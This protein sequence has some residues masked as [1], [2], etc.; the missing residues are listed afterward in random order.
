MDLLSL[1][2]A[3]RYSKAQQGTPSLRLAH[4]LMVATTL[5]EAGIVTAGA[6]RDVSKLRYQ[7]VFLMGAGGSGKGFVGERWMKYMPGA[8]PEG[9]SADRGV[10]QEM[11][12]KKLDE[13]E[14][15]L[16]NLNFEKTVEKLKQRGFRIELTEGGEAARVPFRLYTYD[17]NNR[18][19]LVSPA[20]YDN[21]LPNAIL[22]QVR[23]LESVVFKTPV[24]ELPS[25]WRQVNPD[26]YKEE[27]AGYIKREPGYVHEMSSEMSKAYFEAILESGDPV[28]VDQTGANPGKVIAQI[29]TARAAGYKT[30]VILVIV[31]LTVNEIRNALRPRN[32]DPMIVATQW[33]L[34]VDSF[35]KVRTVADKARVVINRNDSVDIQAYT[36]NSDA[37]NTF[38]RQKTHYKS[39]YDLVAHEAPSELGEWGTILKPAHDA[40]GL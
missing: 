40:A 12:E 25:Y 26:V 17:Q 9:L 18:E 30:S 34:I 19:Q 22:E 1:K 10:R 23:G 15:G 3:C 28:F 20:D 21:L 11:F 37:V 32:V 14:R 7:A 8:P 38:I 2:V 4:Q 29:N 24:H 36:Q 31:P 27:L 16:T 6:L 39:L 5:V 33:N 35:S 13:A